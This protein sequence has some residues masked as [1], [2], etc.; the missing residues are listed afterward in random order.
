MM[1]IEL[2]ISQYMDGELSSEEEAELHHALALSPEAR[3]LFREHL[4]LQGVA[5]DERVLHRPSDDM[6]DS[7]FARLQ[8]EEGMKPVAA[9]ASLSTAVIP[10]IGP[11]RRTVSHRADD[12]P[13][14][15]AAENAPTEERRRRR[16]LVP[17]LIPFVI[18]MI[19]GS[20]WL[21]GGF[22]GGHDDGQQLAVADASAERG[23]AVGSTRAE[24]RS[25]AEEVQAP[26]TDEEHVPAGPE[27]VDNGLIAMNT[28]ARRSVAAESSR[29]FIGVLQGGETV[30][31]S[32][33]VAPERPEPRTRIT[34]NADELLAL[35]EPSRSE[36][37]DVLGN[38]VMSEN[39][40]VRAA[41]SPE[42]PRFSIRGGRSQEVDVTEVDRSSGREYSLAE[43]ESAKSVTASDT[44]DG[45]EVLAS[46][47]ALDSEEWSRANNYG[48]GGGL[49]P[50]LVFDS[51]PSFLSGSVLDSAT[52]ETLR[53]DETNY[54]EVG[55]MIRDLFMEGNVDTGTVTV[56]APSSSPDYYFSNSLPVEPSDTIAMGEGVIAASSSKYER[57]VP[58][59]LSEG[60]RK[61]TFQV[62]S[63]QSDVPLD[64]APG[65]TKDLLQPIT[66]WTQSTFFVGLEQNAGLSL[67]STRY[68]ESALTSLPLENPG[69]T[70]LPSTRLKFGYVI[71]GGRHMVFAALGAVAYTKHTSVY[72]QSTSR[73]IRNVVN[74]GGSGLVPQLV[75]TVAMSS[76]EKEENAWDLHAGVGYRYSTALAGD[77]LAGAEAYAGAGPNYLHASLSLPFS[78]YL[79]RT[80]RLEFSPG[81]A[82]RKAWSE[83]EIVTAGEI[84]Q[85]A[86]L[87][88]YEQRLEVPRESQGVQAMVGI[89]L[90]LLLD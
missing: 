62:S 8:S 76:E 68:A 86:S 81:L 31:N 54:V 45:Y 1:D 70:V 56:L 58:R 51:S 36:E 22:G 89:G 75:N 79:A 82:Y 67:S 20:F 37:H 4:T 43:F 42:E 14:V 40:E 87:S 5:R 74:P 63:A 64:Q 24:T 38:V 49:S 39:A 71:D 84:N 28:E 73:Q 46:D 41:V 52:G 83:G 34:A 48:R 18:C 80:L 90:I 23:D 29:N 44:L 59:P 11:D 10:N 9:V 17:I 30:R 57:G 25:D 77:W 65:T 3:V 7:L 53:V 88:S 47:D 15:A 60:R 27:R 78:Y 13:P 19:A 2:L 6:R 12:R 35:N 16:R 55:N 32:R 26:E 21:S 69:E 61:G 85:S 66:G 33:L 72:T 50:V